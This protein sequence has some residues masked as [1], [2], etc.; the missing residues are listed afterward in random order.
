MS[1]AGC[2][3]GGREQ[4]GVVQTWSAGWRLR[5]QLPAEHALT[6][7][8]VAQLVNR[9]AL[10][11]TKEEIDLPGPASAWEADLRRAGF[12]VLSSGL[13]VD[14]EPRLE[15]YGIDGGLLWSGQFRGADPEEEGAM[16][17]DT[18]LLKRVA[19]GEAVAPY[20]PV[21]CVSV[22]PPGGRTKGLFTL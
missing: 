16:L 5:Y 9:R 7:W 13:A 12:T 15:I 22:L 8:I 1:R 21:G 11:G 3:T 2:E 4:A 17:L 14:A 20:V 10:P 18:V 19:R 6:P